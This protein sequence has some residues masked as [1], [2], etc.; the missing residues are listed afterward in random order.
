MVQSGWISESFETL[1]SFAWCRRGHTDGSGLEVG[2]GGGDGDCDG[3]GRRD[4]RC[5]GARR[6]EVGAYADPDVNLVRLAEIERVQCVGIFEVRA[7][8]VEIRK[9]LYFAVPVEYSQLND[10]STRG[11]WHGGRD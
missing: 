3:R 7:G 2:S 8:Q 10:A 6:F 9:D 4:I 1:G 5:G 11:L